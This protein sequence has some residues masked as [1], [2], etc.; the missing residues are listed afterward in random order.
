MTALI[1]RWKQFVPLLGV[2]ALLGGCSSRTADRPFDP[3]EER[4]LELGNAYVNATNRLGRPPRDFKELEPSLQPGAPADI[5]RSPHDGEP[6]VIFWGV[7]Y[8]KLPPGP[9]DPFTVAAHEA[10][11]RN[12][13]RYVLR[14][15]RSVVLMTDEELSKAVFPPGHKPPR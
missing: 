11:G 4:L 2:L 6:Y 7:D 9:T 5:L 3:S 8:Y 1:P 13:K 12:G 14:F 15:P 10:R